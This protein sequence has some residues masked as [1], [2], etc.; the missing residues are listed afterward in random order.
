MK[1]NKSI[2]SESVL[3]RM[4]DAYQQVKY[5]SKE[6]ELRNNPKVLKEVAYRGFDDFAKRLLTMRPPINIKDLTSIRDPGVQDL[7]RNNLYNYIFAYMV[8]GEGANTQTEVASEIQK[9][10]NDEK[11]KTPPTMWDQRSIMAF[12]ELAAK[13]RAEKL[14]EI[15]NKLDVTTDNYGDKI[16]G[17]LIANKDLKP[18]MEI[19]LSGVDILGTNTDIIIRNVNNKVVVYSST[20]IP[21]PP[22]PDGTPGDPNSKENIVPRGPM[23]KIEHPTA[24]NAIYEVYKSAGE[25][26]PTDVVDLQN[27][28]KM[29][30]LQNSLEDNQEI[31][32][33]YFMTSAI[34][35]TVVIRKNGVYV[36]EYLNTSSSGKMPTKVSVPPRVDMYQVQRDQNLANLY[37]QYLRQ[38]TT[39]VP[40]EFEA[41]TLE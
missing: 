28:Q 35:N 3:S 14:I 1:A 23:F 8:G 32:F 41:E 38:P 20:D 34:I 26:S 2:I 21:K 22:N 31:E 24:L 9:L 11:K 18:N 40:T 16:L 7:I 4:K 37:A 15:D 29:R 25:P 39:P 19:Q 10:V 13:K 33:N 27:A 5:G 17:N 36:T 12:F 6:V 30:E